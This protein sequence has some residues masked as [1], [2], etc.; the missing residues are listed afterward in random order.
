[1]QAIN[2]TPFVAENFVHVDRNG[3]EQ[4]VLVAKA[5]FSI[6]PGTNESAVYAKQRPI[7]FEDSWV[8]EPGASSVRYESD[9]GMVKTSTN[10]ALIGHAYPKFPERR[11]VDVGL[12]IGDTSK[13]V[14][15][16]GDRFWQE[17]GMGMTTSPPQVFEKMPLVFERAF[18]GADNSHANPKNHEFEARNPVGRGFRASTSTALIDGVTLPNLEDPNG[19]IRSA[20]DRPEPCG[21]GFTGAHWLPRLRYQGTYDEA[22]MEKRM[23]LPPLDFDER[24]YNS[25]APGLTCP[26]YLLGGEPVVVIGA[27]SDG[28]RS[29]RL[30]KVSFNC[31][32]C[33]DV[34]VMDL[35]VSLNTI[36]VDTD[37][38]EIVL[39][40]RGS[41][42]IHKRT[43]E[44]R[45]THV[46]L[47]APVQ[48]AQMDE[49]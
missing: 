29:F 27:T 22:W 47:D 39:V 9:F 43:E 49:A 6:L 17:S 32:I 24:F 44:V 20:N 30:P 18:G 46:V 14:R 41:F 7:E 45:W 16:F 21:L 11:Q 34:D 25:A 42:S 1:M 48:F 33:I 31:T 15:V 28:R 4:L 36:V 8:G 5:T 26:D 12:K 37:A 35:P 40:W 13:L 23:P 10:I 2:E 38:E 19:L 3:G